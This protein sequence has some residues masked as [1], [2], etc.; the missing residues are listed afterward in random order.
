MRCKLNI[1]SPV[2]RMIIKELR[3][4]IYENYYKRIGFP[5]FNETSEKEDFLLLVATKLIKKYLVLLISKNNINLR[6]Q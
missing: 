6:H 4:F 1:L 5:K 3:Y 2:K